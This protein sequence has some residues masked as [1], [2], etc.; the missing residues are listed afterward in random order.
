[1]PPETG[2]RLPQHAVTQN[3]KTF[4]RFATVIA[5][6]EDFPRGGESLG[7]TSHKQPGAHHHYLVNDGRRWLANPLNSPNE[8][9]R[10]KK[11]NDGDP[12]RYGSPTGYGFWDV[13]RNAFTTRHDTQGPDQELDP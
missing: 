6:S 11:E 12:E 2:I 8:F 1:M 9:F 7:T 5:A 3:K 13:V 4:C 10:G